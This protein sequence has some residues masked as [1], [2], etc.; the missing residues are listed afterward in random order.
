MNRFQLNSQ[1]ML[2]MG[3]GTDGSIFV[4]FWSLDAFTL[5]V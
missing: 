5:Q 2:L 3:H 4:I 1:E